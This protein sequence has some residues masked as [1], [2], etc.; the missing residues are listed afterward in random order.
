MARTRCTARAHVIVSRSRRETGVRSRLRVVR[1][2]VAPR[3]RDMRIEV[4]GHK[5]RRNT[6]RRAQRSAVL[7]AD[8]P[9]ARLRRHALQSRPQHVSAQV[10]CCSSR[11]HRAPTRK[12]AT[13]KPPPSRLAHRDIASTIGLAPSFL[14]LTRSVSSP[15][16]AIADARKPA[17]SVVMSRCAAVAIPKT[18]F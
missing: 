13:S 8:P 15:S 9:R 1:Y 12:R 17:L 5:S 6:P 7:I 18:E 3:T 11:V 10:D 4:H 2:G 16:A 14:T